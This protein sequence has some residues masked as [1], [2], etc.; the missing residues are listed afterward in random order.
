VL[1]CLNGPLEGAGPHRELLAFWELLLKKLRESERVL[2]PI[3]TQVGVATNALEHVELALSVLKDEN[4]AKENKVLK[5]L[6]Q[7]N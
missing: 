6:S 4:E 2:L 7:E 1:A 3:E 5:K